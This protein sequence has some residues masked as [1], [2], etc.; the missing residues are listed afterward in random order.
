MTNRKEKSAA[1]RRRHFARHR[2]L[3]AL[4]Q[5]QLAGQDLRDIEKQFL[6]E[7]PMDGV[8]REYFHELLFG[9]P[10]QLT[11]LDVQLTPWLDRGLDALDPVEK[12]ILRLGVYELARRLDIPYRVAINEA[13]ELAKQFGAEQS[14]RY[15]NGVLDRVARNHPMRAAEIRAREDEHKRSKGRS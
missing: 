10:S 7:M 14:H 12:A 8:D 9:V 1:R 11:E 3:Q 4:Y 6:E 2:A 5:W 13:V 15:I